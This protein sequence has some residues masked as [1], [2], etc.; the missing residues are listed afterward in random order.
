MKFK[1]I[2]KKILIGLLLAS[3]S[4]F[5]A[6]PAI[7]QDELRYCC[8]NQVYAAFSKENIEAFSKS[9]GIKVVVKTASSGSCVYSL[10]KGFCDIAS[11]ARKLYRRHE[12]YGY[13]EFPFC[14]DPI[15]VIAKKNCGVESL[16]EE[17]LEDIFAGEITNWK[18]VGGNDIPIMVVVPD[19]DTAAHKNFRRQVMKTKEIE[20]EFMAY[21][22]TMVLEAIEYFPCGSVSFISRGAAV[23][24][25]EIRILQINGLSPTDHKYPYHQIFYYFTKGEPKGDVKKFIDYTYSEEGARI[26]R[27]Y[28]MI[29]IER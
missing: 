15:A 24:H 29:P 20:H 21:N 25:P 27:K 2:A 22:S 4:L 9:T 13:S 26:I 12:I 1:P 28:G 8:S 23:Q 17:Q 3:C 19:R 11:S 7:S 5:W 18:D 10:G 6:S 16:T 14:K